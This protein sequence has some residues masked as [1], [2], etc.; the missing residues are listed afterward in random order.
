[1]AAFAG[2]L[3][4]AIPVIDKI[5]TAIWPKGDDKK[6]VVKKDATSAVSAQKDASV[7]AL[8]SVGE[9]LS[10][11]ATLL[12]SC[13]P[14]EDGVVSMRG[15]LEANKGGA[16][17][18][19]DKAAIRRSWASVKRNI[20]QISDKQTKTAVEL[21]GD[22][23]TKSTFLDVI[24]ADI[25]GTD[26]DVKDWATDQLIKDVNGLY[27]CLNQANKVAAQVIAGIAVG[28]KQASDAQKK[29]PAATTT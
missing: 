15:V 26:E 13:L 9:E 14:A 10:I 7:T 24:N 29:K 19:A 23:F 27:K 28:L 5:V 21:I 25:D 3:A 11:I 1:M 17:G 4:A 6:R 12:E 20:K 8:K 16:L 22:V 2:A 18:E